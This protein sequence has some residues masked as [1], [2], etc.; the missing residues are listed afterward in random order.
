MKLIVFAE[1]VLIFIFI[2]VTSLEARWSE[3]WE[4]MERIKPRNYVCYRALSPIN[5]DGKLEED[6]WQKAPWTEDFADIEGDVKPKPT[7]QTRA[8]MLW[9]DNCFY[10]GAQLEEPHV[11]ATLTEHD[12]V[13]FYDNDFEIFID[14]DGDSHQYYEIE[15]NAFGTEWD[16][17]LIKPYKDGGPAVDSWEIPGLKIG[18]YVDGTINNP[19]DTDKGWS[20]ELAFPWEIL[21]ECA[22]RKTPPENG[23][24][25]RI[26]FSRVEW[27]IEVVDGKYKKIPK[28]RENNW[29][30]S[31]QGVIDMHRPEKWG[32][33]QFSTAEFGKDKF[34][35]DPSLP[36]RF[37]LQR[38]YYAQKDYKDAYGSWAKSLEELGLDN[39]EG[40]P[41]MQTTQ[42]G[43]EITVEKID[44]N[45]KKGI[46]HISHDG[47]VWVSE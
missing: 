12:S 2:G 34:R 32:F 31:P 29:I 7:Y 23:D 14:P 35:P 42:S 27:D 36:I 10:I 21:S 38:I 3:D 19:S 44:A 18:V 30:W 5:I 4:K 43:Y 33:V 22:H 39:I 9:D 28:K 11:W 20:V 47:R 40:N 26:N 8:K 46:W 6:S 24:Q 41:L 16:L 17:L 25:W 45:G 37:L 1:F 13:I 15:L